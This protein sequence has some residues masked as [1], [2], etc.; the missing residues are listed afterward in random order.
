MSE[1]LVQPSAAHRAFR[2]D[3]IVLLRKYAGEMDAAAMLALSAHLTGQIIAMQDQRT[4]TQALALEI[5]ERNLE[6]G[7]HEAINGL[8][9]TKGNG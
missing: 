3:L 8:F 7:N 5:V 6:L 4:M 2:D 1:H 9:D